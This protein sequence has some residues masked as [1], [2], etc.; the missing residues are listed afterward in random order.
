MM[1]TMSVRAPAGARRPTIRD[2]A[3]RAK[4]SKS[5]VSLVFS[6]PSSVGPTRRQRVLKAAAEL[7]YRPNQVARSLNGTRED[8]VGIL[9]SDPRNPV[10]DEVVESARQEL[11]RAGRLG[12]VTSAVRP[13][14]GEPRL[15]EAVVS[16]VADLRPAAVMIVGSVP[17]MRQI[18]Q[19]VR[20]ARIVVA[21]AFPEGIESASVRGDDELGIRL[22]VDHLAGLGHRRIAHVG[23]GMRPVA[24][25]RAQAFEQASAASGCESAGIVHADFTE[26]GGYRAAC[27]LLEHTHPPTAILAVNDLAGI[28]ALAAV[29]ERGLAKRVAVTGYDNTYL[30]RLGPIDLTSVEPGNVEIGRRAARL[31][32]DEVAPQA[33]V[34]IRPELVARGSTTRVR[35][36]E[37]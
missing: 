24:A 4:V 27:T 1:V 9:V 23:G 3:E 14:E 7:G 36:P 17:G 2:V 6:A 18:A 22:L 32:M 21:S 26:R 15:D 25:A 13:G 11:E 29:A 28:G 8:I 37:S 33:E 35:P 16:M 19:A 5:L 34:L 12:L 20:G 30:A 31:L 10:L